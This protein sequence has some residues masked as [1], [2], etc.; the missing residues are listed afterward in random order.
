M[1]TSR[2]S[3][4]F[5]AAD[6]DMTVSSS[7][8]VLFKVHRKNLEACSSVFANVENTTQSQNG[9]ET[10]I[11]RH[12]QPDLDALEFKTFA[13]LAEA[14]EKYVVDSA[15]TMCRM[16]M[17]ASVS[18]YPLEVLLYAVR[19]EHMHLAN[20][21]AQ[22]SMRCGV[23][24][25]LEVLPSDIFRPWILFHE[26]WHNETFRGLTEMMDY[27]SHIPLTRIQ[28]SLFAKNWTMPALGEEDFE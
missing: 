1:T 23:A 22:S 14:A 17:K 4:R 20:E 8:G 11:Y 19:H 6:P 15:L 21:A 27:D 13:S 18:A 10:F 9:D 12:P 5:W 25:G 24:D 7:D 26:R 2:I 28:S 3:G 16:K